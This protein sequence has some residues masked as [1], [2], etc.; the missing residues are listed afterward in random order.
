MSEAAISPQEVSSSVS[1]INAIVTMLPVGDMQ[2]SVEFYR[3]LGF[4][5]GNREPH[6]GTPHWVWLYMPR[7]KDWKRGPNLMLV[8]SQNAPSP[9]PQMC[10]YLYATD[11]VALRQRLLARGVNAGEIGY[12]EYLPEGE[13]KVLDPDGYILMIAQAGKDT[14]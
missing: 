12:P 10:F 3:L 5:I 7:A 4:E 6:E 1:D 14:P 11:M 9:H 2:R 13:F 8:R